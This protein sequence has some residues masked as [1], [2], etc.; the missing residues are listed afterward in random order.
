MFKINYHQVALSME[1][2]F[3]TQKEYMAIDDM[4]S[5][6]IS[7]IIDEFESNDYADDIEKSYI[8]KITKKV[9]RT[10]QAKTIKKNKKMF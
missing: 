5:E 8:S 6:A 10:H 9:T 7:N 1:C 2:D 3:I 4:R